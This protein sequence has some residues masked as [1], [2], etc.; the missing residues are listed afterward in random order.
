MTELSMGVLTSLF[1]NLNSKFYMKNIIETANMFFSD[2]FV[3]TRSPD[4]VGASV[5]ARALYKITPLSGSLRYAS[6]IEEDYQKEL[7]TLNDRLLALNPFK[8]KDSIMPKRNMYGEVIDRNKGWFFGLGGK[9]GLWS[10][11][12]AMTKTDN[13]QIQKFYENRDFKYVPP[14]KIDRKSGVDLRTIKNAKEQTAYDRW[15]EL[16]GQVTISYQGER[17]TLK[18]LIEKVIQDPKSRLYKLPD[19]T[20][21][22]VDERQKFI[23]EF[24]HKAEAKAK[25][26]LLREFPNIKDMRKNRKVIKRNAKK[27][28]KKNYIEILT[29]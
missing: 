15:R 26:Q 23:L 21:A 6:R 5:L 12:F 17:L 3:S 8:G 22:G 1:R 19:G 24:V 29:Q 20:I 7:F 11:P 10:S 18:K 27:R 2:D 25:K 9:T 16:T 4:K 28:A 13:P 14:A